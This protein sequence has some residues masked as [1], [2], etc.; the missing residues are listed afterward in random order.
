[1]DE[2]GGALVVQ[3]QESS[4]GL[5]REREIKAAPD[6]GRDIESLSSKK[7]F[8]KESVAQV[9]GEIEPLLHKHWHEIAHYKDIPLNPDW[10]RYIQVEEAGALRVFTV[11]KNEKLI[12]YCVYLLNKN[13]HYKDSLQAL[14]DILFI[15][16]EHRGGGMKFLKWC[17]EQ[18]RLEGVQAVYQHIKLKH[19]FGPM[20]ERL[21]YELVD[22]IYAKRLDLKGE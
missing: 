15:D 14:Q 19:N 10:S 11:R 7:T 20:L 13:M 2:R 4:L 21:G 8:Q 12:G 9:I 17:D 22:L 1:M 5:Q 3:S 6:S 18:L 16:P